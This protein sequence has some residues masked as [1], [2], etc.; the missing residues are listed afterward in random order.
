MRSQA[1]ALIA[2]DDDESDLRSAGFNYNIAPATHDGRA[3]IFVSKCDQRDMIAEVDLHEEVDFLLRE[4]A[5]HR[6]KAPLQRLGACALDCGEHVVLVVRPK[7]P[8]FN[9]ASIAKLF[10]GSIVPSLGHDHLPAVREDCGSG[11][12]C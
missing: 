3:A 4:A 12:E 7:R 9:L 1:L 10:D 8:D 5:L 6:E 11:C 2:V